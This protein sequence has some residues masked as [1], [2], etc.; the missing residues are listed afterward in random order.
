VEVRKLNPGMRAWQACPGEYY[1]AT[2]GQKSGLWKDLGRSPQKLTGVGFI[3]EG[4][5][6]A[7]PL[8]AIKLSPRL[9][10]A[11]AFAIQPLTLKQ[12]RLH[13]LCQ[14]HDVDAERDDRRRWCQVE[15]G[16][17]Q[18]PMWTSRLFGFATLKIQFGF[19]MH[20]LTLSLKKDVPDDPPN[21]STAMRH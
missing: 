12:D 10:A 19:L 6:S 7:M 4:F 2:T 5:D 1:L 16:A 8:D 3:S 15:F 13:C 14:R 11:R 20:G 21:T 17:A 9:A 18:H